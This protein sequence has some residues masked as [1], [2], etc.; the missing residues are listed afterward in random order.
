ML[1]A[2]QHCRVTTYLRS[3]YDV[4][5][6]FLHGTTPDTCIALAALLT[7]ALPDTRIALCE[8]QD[9]RVP[10]VPCAGQT[11]TS[12]VNIRHH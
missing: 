6:A 5:D 1:L 8:T 4:T 10:R 3:E 7:H 9:R 12:T 2:L 11:S